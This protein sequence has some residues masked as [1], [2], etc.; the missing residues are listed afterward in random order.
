MCFGQGK[1]S[2][3]VLQKIESLQIQYDDFYDQGL[4][5][6][7]RYWL[8]KQGIDDNNI[9][10]SASL[11]Y[12]LSK[13]NGENGNPRIEKIISAVIQNY[14][15]YRSRRGRA[16]YNHWQTIPPDLPFPNS[17]LLSKEK[18]R[19][20]DDLDNTVI[21]Q[22]SRGKNDLD[23]SVRQY[24]NDY[25]H[26]ENR[27]DPPQFPEKYLSY[28][29][30]EVWFADKM[31]Q[32]YDLIVMTNVLLFV[33]EKEY[34]LSDTDYQTIK[35]IKSIVRDKFHLL[36]PEIA[37]PYYRNSS[38]I[39]YHLSRLIANDQTGIFDD[40][41]NEIF[42]QIKSLLNQHITPMEKV[43]LHNA[44]AKINRQIMP[45]IDW[46]KLEK[47]IK[48]FRFFA[49]LPKSIFGSMIPEVAWS[50]EALNWTLVYEF[51]MYHRQINWK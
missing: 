13:I 1:N 41:E 40:I 35:L 22:L 18:Y 44:A 19:L 38:L 6:T 43:L 45:L 37:S 42:N 9:F 21:I 5:P 3:Y 26:R 23:D 24:L 14:E 36:T 50:C 29:P 25:S 47:N 49:Y 10:P 15:K 34:K 27:K 4:F 11:S 2:E 32:D 7:T 48:E 46:Q 33:F 20:P 31:E 51:M 28:K 16:S 12:I 17:L 30:H 39:L 8:N